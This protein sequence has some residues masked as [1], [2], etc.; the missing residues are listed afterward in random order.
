M[1]GSSFPHRLQ[2]RYPK[3][4][5]R[6]LRGAAFLRL[7]GANSEGGIVLFADSV[8]GIVF[9]DGWNTVLSEKSG[10]RRNGRL[11][12]SAI[13]TETGLVRRS[14]IKTGKGGIGQ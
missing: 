14:C 8:S 11:K 5:G 4:Q 1:R 13:L 10:I 2:D 12:K 7:M 6:P 9:A 3:K